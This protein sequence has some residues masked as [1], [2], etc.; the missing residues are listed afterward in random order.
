M[1]PVIALPLEPGKPLTLTPG[2]YQI[3]LIEL[4]PPL[5]QG[6]SFPL[7]LTFEHAASVTVQAKVVGPGAP[8]PM[9]SDI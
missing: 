4:E 7:M 3:M 2:G 1:C 9:Q 6:Q 8:A 5:K